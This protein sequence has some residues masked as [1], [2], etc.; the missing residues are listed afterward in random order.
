MAKL[1]PMNPT[2]NYE[3]AWKELKQTLPELR[4]YHSFD[5]IIEASIDDMMRE[6]ET[7]HKNLITL[8]RRS[9][10]EIVDYCIRKSVEA[11][12]EVIYLKRKLREE[13]EWNEGGLF[14][15][16]IVCE[17]KNGRE[18]TFNRCLNNKKLEY[19]NTAFREGENIRYHDI[20]M[21]I[22]TFNISYP[23]KERG[24]NE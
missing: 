3:G 8:K 7:K 21:R 17:T 16:H 19:Y 18:Y 24:N 6:L 20:E 5:N 22:T 10:S 13:K 4:K 1:K 23:I 11:R 15:V 9:D 14:D 2:V 12:M